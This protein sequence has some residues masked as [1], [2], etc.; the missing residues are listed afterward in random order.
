MKLR[1]RAGMMLFVIVLVLSLFAVPAYARWE[2]CPTD[3]V[4]NVGGKTVSVVV[5]LAPADLANANWPR[6]VKVSLKAPKGT[7]PYVVDINSPVPME[8]RAGEWGKDK[9]EIKVNVPK[10]D[11][12]QGMQVQ[13]F[14]GDEEVASLTT[15]KRKARLSFEWEDD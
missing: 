10:V 2:F 13:V 8:A 15:G 9:V 4:F 6:A 11:G 3:P 7:D 14:V 12:F 5:N 1:T